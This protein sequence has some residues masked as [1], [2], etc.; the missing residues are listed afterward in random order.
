MLNETV[1]VVARMSPEERQ[2][3]RDQA[4]SAL[5]PMLKGSPLP[6]DVL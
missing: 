2:K 4:L 5:D 1:R 6:T 3:V